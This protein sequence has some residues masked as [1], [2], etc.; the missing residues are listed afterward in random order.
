MMVHHRGSSQGSVHG[1][2]M[3][4]EAC[5]HPRQ[6]LLIE[7]HGGGMH[8][9]AH[10]RTTRRRRLVKVRVGVPEPISMEFNGMCTEA[11]NRSAP[12]VDGVPRRRYPVDSGDGASTHTQRRTAGVADDYFRFHR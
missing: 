4:M 7:V 3:H 12:F 9:E 6:W 5:Y 10:G 1:G 2:D 8:V 11:Y